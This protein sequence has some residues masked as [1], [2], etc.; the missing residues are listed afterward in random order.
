MVYVRCVIHT[1]LFSC[2]YRCA[3]SSLRDIVRKMEDSQ[4]QEKP[5]TLYIHICDIFSTAI[6]EI[7]RHLFFFSPM[8]VFSIVKCKICIVSISNQIDNALN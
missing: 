3:K 1:M 2:L 8:I 6:H 7:D 4:R 5:N